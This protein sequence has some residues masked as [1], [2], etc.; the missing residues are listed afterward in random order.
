MKTKIIH[1]LIILFTISVQGQIPTLAEKNYNS[2][3]KQTERTKAI[4]SAVLNENLTER[5]IAVLEAIDKYDDTINIR[6]KLIISLDEELK[7]EKNKEKQTRTLQRK[8]EI[9]KEVAS[10]VKQK[11][12]SIKKILSE[13]EEVN[14]E[15]ES[16]EDE[17]SDARWSQI[18]YINYFY[19]LYDKKIEDNIKKIEKLE[20]DIVGIEAVYD[21]LEQKIK[22]DSIRNIIKNLETE[23]DS[24]LKEY[25]NEY[26]GLFPSWHKEYRND[27][28]EYYYNTNDS[29]TSYL[30]SLAI[31]YNN[32]GTVI[33]SEVIAD[34]F[35]P[36]RIGFGTVVQSN[37]ETPVTEQEI[38]EQKQQDQLEALLNGGG[39]FYIETIL[40]ALTIHN[41][42]IA[43]Y[44]YFN[45]KTGTEIKGFSNNLDTNTFNTSLGSNLYFGMNSD[46][47][48]FNVFMQADFNLILASKSFYQNLQLA[49]EQPFFQ[50]K[51]M[52][53]VTFLSKFRLAA[54]LNSFGSDEALRSGKVILG[55]QIIPGFN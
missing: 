45:N 48:K 47:K 10:L 12:E 37:D 54:I 16:E 34:T 2:K 18:D 46:E 7:K 21:A 13:S 8:E 23:R 36:V 44:S 32:S 35:G 41:N 52:V 43:L 4:V 26:T 20:L 9:E 38:T 19:G 53:G 14:S 39:N 5:K 40:P 28:F 42:S 24:I 55:L 25:R 33:Q 1:L 27:F 30:N 11:K 29:K 6:N 22:V 49:K 50:G 15:S 3:Y 31:N 51:L 17:Y